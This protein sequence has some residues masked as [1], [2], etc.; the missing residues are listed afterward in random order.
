MLDACV[1]RCP[2]L[3]WDEPVVELKFCQVAFHTLIFTDLYLGRDLESLRQQVFHREN[4]AVFADYEELEDRT[5]QQR[6]DKT[7]IKAYLRHC[8]DKVA[9]VIA[10]ETEETLNVRP[11]FKRK[12]FSRAELHVNS[13]RHIHHHAAQLSL[14][15]RLNVN[16]SIPWFSS[17]WQEVR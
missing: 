10:A 3:N 11:G 17:G 8:R 1:D 14:L 6:Y 2:D 12:N 4:E 9:R 13:I 16:E 7:F 15:L 5:P